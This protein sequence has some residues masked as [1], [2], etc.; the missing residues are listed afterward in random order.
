MKPCPFCGWTGDS[1]DVIDVAADSDRKSVG[2]PACGAI[3]PAGK[4]VAEA[5][6]KWNERVVA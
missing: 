2:C 6:T 1:F 3:G 5:E 4:D